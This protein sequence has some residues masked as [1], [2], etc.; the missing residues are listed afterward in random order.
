MPDISN[1]SSARSRA[2]AFG[3]FALAFIGLGVLL[4]GNGADISWTLLSMGVGAG[5]LIWIALFWKNSLRIS[6]FYLLILMIVFAPPLPPFF[7]TASW[8]VHQL[9]L[10]ALAPF[11][12]VWRQRL[13]TQVD[14]WIA[15]SG[16]AIVLSMM[17]GAISGNPPLL[18]DWFELAKPGFWWLIYSFGLGLRWRL[19]QKE[20]ALWILVGVG[21]GIIFLSFAQYADQGN[22]NDWLTPFFI[23]NEDR[24][25]TVA[26]RV[27]GTFGSPTRLS[28]FIT[29]V[30]NIALILA[31]FSQQSKW[32]RTIMVL[33]VGAT[34]VIILMT[35]SK[36]G[37]LAGLVSFSGLVL[38]RLWFGRTS[39]LARALLTM[40]LAIIVVAGGFLLL[41]ET[42][43]IATEFNA[44]QAALSGNPLTSALYRLGGIGEDLDPASAR[45]TDWRTALELGLESPLFGTGPSKGVD[46]RAYFHS[47]Y[48]LIFRRYG[49]V[50]L[51][52]FLALYGS[53]ALSA[54]RAFRAAQNQ[55]DVWRQVLTLST[56]MTVLGFTTDGIFSNGAL[57][58]FQLSA[59]LWW[60]IGLFY[61]SMQASGA[62]DPNV[63]HTQVPAWRNVGSR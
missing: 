1:S 21:I 33:C 9:T 56:L 53:I 17:V 61:G 2:L 31:L 19:E 55:Q 51:I 24:L 3:S 18:Q 37:L 20:R 46:E 10:I 26:Y 4:S 50:G 36:S 23:T 63:A 15:L 34:S 30:L 22:V 27:M 7:G 41:T 25:S 12:V 28:T 45:L 32:L 52:T 6:L 48:L 58:D 42:N 40:L 60:L 38:L 35:G 59:V 47:E 29:M 5:L 62:N 44:R 43:R 16:L 11:I 54:Y 39:E 57:S 14:T 49:L 13:R 8:R